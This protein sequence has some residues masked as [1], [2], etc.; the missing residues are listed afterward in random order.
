M[1]GRL[2]SKSYVYAEQAAWL[3]EWVLPALF[4]LILLGCLAHLGYCAL[5]GHLV[6]ATGFRYAISAFAT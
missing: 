6:P 5:Q 4:T 1:A 2:N 3:V